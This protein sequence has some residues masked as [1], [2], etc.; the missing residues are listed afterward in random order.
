GSMRDALSL[1]DKLLSYESKCLTVE[2]ADAVIPPP[3]DELAFAVTACVS[4]RD[5]AHTPIHPS[6]VTD[7]GE[8]WMECF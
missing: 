7:T 5:S 6:P 2:V 3:H 1:L 4:N 8:P